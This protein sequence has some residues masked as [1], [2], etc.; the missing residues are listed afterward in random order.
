RPKPV[1][2]SRCCNPT[3]PATYFSLIVVLVQPR[4]PIVSKSKP[5]WGQAKEFDK[6]SQLL[7][8]PLLLG[9]AGARVY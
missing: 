8:R 4:N 3:H 1:L 7:E 6:P 2:S 9:T 5:Y